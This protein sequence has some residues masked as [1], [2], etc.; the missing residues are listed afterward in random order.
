MSLK[1]IV[2]PTLALVLVATG[3]VV[4]KASAAPMPA[5][6]GQDRDDWRVP[7]GEFNEIQRRGF[8]DGM[9]G[10]DRDYGNKRRPDVNNREEYREPHVEPQ[11]RRAYQEA[12]RRGYEVAASHLYG[13]QQAPPPMAVVQAPEHPDWE[14]WG[15]RGLEND[16]SR[17]GY[18]EGVE[19]ARKD[20]NSQRR[21]DPDD[22][23]EFTNPPVPRELADEY[24]E[25]FV[26]GY[27]VASSQLAGEPAWQ[28]PGQ[29][30]QW[31]PP[32]RFSEWQRRGFQEGVEGARK[33]FGNHRRPNV[34][35]R[36]EYRE[37]RI[38]QQFWRE[39]RE[40]FRRGYEMSAAQL[41]GG[42]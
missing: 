39:Y 33:D 1:R 36:E 14:R 4:T 7:P 12:Y 31:S 40:G 38:P 9:E 32:E 27:E 24:R 2:G 37:P 16:A 6:Y 35:N 20:F 17:S 5:G 15:M 29:S 30:G 19:E 34:V 42:V 21:A 13:G 10:A 22:H 28:N 26:R 18:R 41:W 8:H 3:L 23:Q 25:G 11:L